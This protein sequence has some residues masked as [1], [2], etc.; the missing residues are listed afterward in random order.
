M[1]VGEPPEVLCFADVK[2]FSNYVHSL[3]TTRAYITAPWVVSLRTFAIASW[4]CK[5]SQIDHLAMS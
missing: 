5:P 3:L 4:A 1:H 2:T